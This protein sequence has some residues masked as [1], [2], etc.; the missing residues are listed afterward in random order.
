[1]YFIYFASYFA[2]IVIIIANF[3]FLRNYWLYKNCLKWNNLVYNHIIFFIIMEIP[4]KCTS[5]YMYHLLDYSRSFNKF[6]IWDVRKL[7]D[8]TAMYDY[9]IN[10]NNKIEAHN[11]IM[12]SLYDKINNDLYESEEMKND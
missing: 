12:L 8:D 11:K 3:L 6:W 10:M 2:I 4:T 7:I 1:M 5:Q 9:I